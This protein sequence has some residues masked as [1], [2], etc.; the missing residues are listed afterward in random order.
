M[1][2]QLIAFGYLRCSGASQESG[3]GFTRQ[4]EKI[5]M[6][7]KRNK[8]VVNQV[9][10][11]IITGTSNSDDRPVFQ[12]M[13]ATA[14]EQGVGIIIIERLDRIARDLLVQEQ[15]LLCLRKKNIRLMSV[16]EP[17][18][19]N[20][21][22]PS[23]TLIRQ[24][25]GA[26]AQADKSN[27]VKKL[28]TARMRIRESGVRC[29]GQKPYGEAVD[30]EVRAQEQNVLRTIRSLR[31]YGEDTPNPVRRLLRPTPINQICL[32][33]NLRGIKPRSATS[34]SRQAISNILEREEKKR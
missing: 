8:L 20:N 30:P 18:I 31:I 14:L 11:E 26:V 16:D 10:Q 13:L 17:D 2:T 4:S 24:I 1:K 33:L 23:R 6:Y 34:W 21:D 3:D 19:D 28:A 15:T 25:L 29:D 32:A 12:E 27:L 9:F 7:A 22:D 5:G